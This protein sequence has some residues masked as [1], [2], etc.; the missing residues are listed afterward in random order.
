M[1]V[2][3]DVQILRYAAVGARADLR[4]MYT[5]KTWTGGWLLRVLAQVAF[6]ALIGRLLGSDATIRYLAVGNSVVIAAIEAM[7]VVA[8]TTWERRSGTLP[9]LIAAPGSTFLVWLGRS[10]QWLPSGTTSA[11]ISF[12]VVGAMVGVP[13][14]FPGVLAV[15]ALIALTAFTTY[16]FGLTLA[17]L[18]LRAMDLRNVVSN[19][20][21]LSLMAL[22]GV[23]VPVSYWP[24]AVRWIA[25]VLPLTHALAAVRE[26]VAGAGFARVVS[27]AAPELAVAAGWL[28]VS[29]LLFRWLSE[30]GRKDGSIEFG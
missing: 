26:L 4:A 29:F 20:A 2:A 5:W 27:T 24:A 9:L 18:V 19:V 1:S 8:S 15:V 12:F 23:E 14:R 21:Y 11:T 13:L 16:C 10:V 3:G 7:F 28:I 6:F 22:T 30:S 17:A 25:D